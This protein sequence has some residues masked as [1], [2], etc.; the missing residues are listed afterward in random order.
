MS[1]PVESKSR[2]KEGRKLP[3]KSSKGDAGKEKKMKV[4]IVGLQG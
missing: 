2:K 3:I 4:V 1:K